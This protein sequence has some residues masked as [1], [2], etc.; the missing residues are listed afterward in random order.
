MVKRHAELSQLPGNW[1]SVRKLRT[2]AA[3]G[4]SV[5]ISTVAGSSSCL[6][7]LKDCAENHD[8][9]MCILKLMLE[10]RTCDTPA[11]ETM[12]EKCREFLEMANFPDKSAGATMVVA[13]RDAW[14]AK[15]CLTFLKRKWARNEVP[16]DA[17]VKELVGMYDAICAGDSI[18]RRES[19]EDDILVEEEHEQH[20]VTVES[21]PQVV[22]ADTVASGSDLVP[23]E[24]VASGSDLVPTETVAS[25][26]EVVPTETVASGSEVVPT[27]TIASGTEPR[28]ESRITP[29]TVSD[30]QDSQLFCYAGLRRD[31]VGHV[32]A[33]DSEPLQVGTQA[34]GSSGSEPVAG[35]IRASEVSGSEPVAV[36]IRASG[37]SGS[38]PVAQEVDKSSRA[39]VVTMDSLSSGREVARPLASLEAK[40]ALSRAKLKA[41]LL[42]LCCARVLEVIADSDDEGSAPAPVRVPVDQ[43]ETQKYDVDTQVLMEPLLAEEVNAMNSTTESPPKPRELFRGQVIEG[44]ASELKVLTRS[45]QLALK[46]SRPDANDDLGDV[47]GPKVK[48]GPGRPKA[49]AGPKAT[50]KS[51]AKPVPKVKASAKSSSS[52]SKGAKKAS[53]ASSPA[54]DDDLLPQ[55]PLEAEGEAASLEGEPDDRRRAVKT[56]RGAFKKRGHRMGRKGKKSRKVKRNTDADDG[57]ADDA[58][59]EEKSMGPSSKRGRSPDV[60]GDDSSESGAAAK[61]AKRSPRA[62]A[63][64][65]PRAKAKS[66]PKAKAKSGPKPK[67]KSNPKPKAKGSPKA[68]AKSSPKAKAK[69]SPKAKAKSSPKAKAKSSPKAK[70]KSSAKGEDTRAPV[71]ESEFSG[72]EFPMCGF[73]YP[74]TFAGRWSPKVPNSHGWYVWRYIAKTFIQIVAPNIRDR[75]RS[76]KELEYFSFAKKNFVESGLNVARP[77]TEVFFAEQAELYLRDFIQR[78]EVEREGDADCD[79][80]SSRKARCS[81]ILLLTIAA[82]GNWNYP[83]GLATRLVEVFRFLQLDVPPVPV[84]D[85]WKGLQGVSGMMVKEELPDDPEDLLHIIKDL[86]RQLATRCS[87]PEATIKATDEELAAAGPEESFA[88]LLFC[89]GHEERDVLLRKIQEQAK[90]LERLKKDSDDDDDSKAEYNRMRAK[91]G[92]L[93]SRTDEF[94]RKVE[95]WKETSKFRELATDGG[96]YSESDMKKPVSEGGLGLKEK[97]KYDE[98][99]TEYWVDHRT[100][101]QVS[102]M[103]NSFKPGNLDEWNLKGA[104]TCEVESGKDKVSDTIL[105][106]MQESVATRDKLAKFADRLDGRDAAAASC[107][108]ASLGTLYDDLAKLQAEAKVKQF[109]DAQPALMFT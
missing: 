103:S 79:H 1:E 68:K 26:S 84:K 52:K 101:G 109:S 87:S 86:E 27:E 32:E 41:Q 24:T 76:K 11:V 107:V 13:H 64:S 81:F 71:E 65:S 43:Q 56:R 67:A 93:C 28:P 10:S 105:R 104:G 72:D 55:A 35:E 51:K 7:N 40:L 31:D 69:S 47:D 3:Q 44:G 6:G 50:A 58:E 82:G 102:G 15:R 14:S 108:I 2:R 73:D 8:A 23:T 98:D 74:K 106:H 99:E 95:V 89:N 46:G 53:E 90:E 25:G 77:D 83:R 37:S 92:R 57:S 54:P 20:L 30:M 62:K 12:S 100:H 17:K 94:M 59:H 22:P 33:A 70:A 66:S 96:F 16:K 48:R 18:I 5:F 39:K 21:G 42:K 85:L 45:D 88:S 60:V 63:K 36:E 34:S 4:H 19:S 91:T 61:K 80:V 9:L 29:M 49:A 38:E 97:C 75:T 78:F